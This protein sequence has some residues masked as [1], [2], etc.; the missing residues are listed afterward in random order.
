VAAHTFQGGRAAP[1][2]TTLAPSRSP[3]QRDTNYETTRHQ[4]Y[5]GN[6]NGNSGQGRCPECTDQANAS[7]ALAAT[8]I[9]ALLISVTHAIRA[10]RQSARQEHACFAHA[11]VGRCTV[12]AVGSRVAVEA[13]AAANGCQALTMTPTGLPHA[14]AQQLKLFKCHSH[15]ALVLDAA[16]CVPE[17][18]AARHIGCGFVDFLMVCVRTTDISVGHACSSAGQSCRH[19]MPVLHEAVVHA[20]P[21]SHRRFPHSATAD[22]TIQ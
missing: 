20:S 7:G 14:S 8:A 6:D 5:A 16:R 2:P 11:H 21:S 3:P 4:H 10:Q 18:E 12:V 17:P 1:F 15:S 9:H 13:L 22:F 19:S